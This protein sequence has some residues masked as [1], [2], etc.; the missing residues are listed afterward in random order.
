M[1][2]KKLAH[3]YFEFFSLGDL[4]SLLKIYDKNI[5]LTDWNGQ[6]VGSK[7]V[8]NINKL[9]FEDYSPKVEVKEIKEVGNRVYCLIEIKVGEEKLKIMDVIDFN[10]HGKIIKIEAFK[11]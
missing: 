4:E 5:S 2:F 8:L 9:L 11:G 10:N 3:K 7:K 1:D 6:W